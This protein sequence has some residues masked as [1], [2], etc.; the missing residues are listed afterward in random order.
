MKRGWFLR[1]FVHDG[2]VCIRQLKEYIFR[3]Q[4][5]QIVGLANN[6]GEGC[7]EHT[8]MNKPAFVVYVFQTL[9]NVLREVQDKFGRKS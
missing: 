1:E 3:F 4:V 8:G 6:K 5:F 9:Q 2:V 7:V